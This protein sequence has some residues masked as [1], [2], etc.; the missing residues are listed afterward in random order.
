MIVDELKLLIK[1]VSPNSDVSNIKPETRLKEDLGLDSL[2]TLML[3]MQI[4]TKFN[5]KFEQLS[6]FKTVK[7]VLDYLASVGITD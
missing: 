1:Q 5:F 6:G 7:E 4:E 3:A 2:S